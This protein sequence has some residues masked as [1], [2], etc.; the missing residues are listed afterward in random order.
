[1]LILTG[2]WPAKPTKLLSRTLNIQSKGKCG[3]I[4]KAMWDEPPVPCACLFQG[5]LLLYFPTQRICMKAPQTPELEWGFVSQHIWLGARGRLIYEINTPNDETISAI[6][7]SQL[8]AAKANSEIL[9]QVYCDFRALTNQ[10]FVFPSWS[11][12]L[13]TATEPQ[14]H[15][16]HQLT[17]HRTEHFSC[18]HVQIFHLCIC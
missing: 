2:C 13:V 5:M 10:V 6:E 16:L 12:G 3:P 15:K 9:Q 7:P 17:C 4:F 18:S 11:L 14:L 8:E 1:M